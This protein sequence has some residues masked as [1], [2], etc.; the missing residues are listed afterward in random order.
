MMPRGAARFRAVP[1]VAAW[2][3]ALRQDSERDSLSLASVQS[4]VHARLCL[5]LSTQSV[6]NRFTET[7]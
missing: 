4:A 5:L 7:V 1:R 3:R 6:H 2:S